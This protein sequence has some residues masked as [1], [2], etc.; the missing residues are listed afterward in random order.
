VFQVGGVVQK[1]PG[2]RG[3]GR[4]WQG[5]VSCGEGWEGV[6]GNL[7]RAGRLAV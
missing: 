1:V 4:V 5:V 7:C 2:R 3:A 6:S